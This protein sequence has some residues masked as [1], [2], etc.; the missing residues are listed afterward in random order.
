LFRGICN[1]AHLDEERTHRIPVELED[2]AGIIDLFVTI[3]RTTAL[4][5]A[6]NDGESS[7]NVALDSIPSRLTEEDIQH[8]VRNRKN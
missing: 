2:N 6:T 4:Q 8:Y 3:T 5:E 1:L 7:A